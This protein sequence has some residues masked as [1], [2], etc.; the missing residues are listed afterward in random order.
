MLSTLPYLLLVTKILGEW[1]QV[2]ANSSV[3]TAAFREKVQRPRGVSLGLGR[4][5]PGEFFLFKRTQ[6]CLK[7]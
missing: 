1:K 3:S 2:V 6:Y 4:G 7:I 5:N